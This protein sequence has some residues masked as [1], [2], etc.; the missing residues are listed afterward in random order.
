MLHYME[1]YSKEALR[2]SLGRFARSWERKGADMGAR[3]S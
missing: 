1:F 2:A 3:L